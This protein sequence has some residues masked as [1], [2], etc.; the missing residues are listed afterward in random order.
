LLIAP[1]TASYA[2]DAQQLLA[3]L[4]QSTQRPP[5]FVHTHS[6]VPP[7]RPI[8]SSGTLA[9][10]APARFEKATLEPKREVLVLDG[11]TLTVTREGRT[12]TVDLR[13]HVQVLSFVEAIRGVL[14]GNAERLEQ[15]YKI[16]VSGSEAAWNI[17]LTPRDLKLADLIKEIRMGG[18]G[19][20]VLSVEYVETGGDR[21]VMQIEPVPHKDRD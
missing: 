14:L 8:R 3:Q 12:I 4:A 10:Q 6:L 11:D 9:F 13:D 21:S 19:G 16:Q 2:F 5:T 7:A 15:L 17:V 18:G 20:Q 1:L